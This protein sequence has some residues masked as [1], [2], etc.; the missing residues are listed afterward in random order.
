[1]REDLR[2][3]DT[4]IDQKVE[5]A[6][7]AEAIEVTEATEVIEVIEVIEAAEAAE[8]TEVA[9]AAS[10]KEITEI[11]LAITIGRTPAIETSMIDLM[12]KVQHKGL[13]RPL[14]KIHL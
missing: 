13:R 8:V 5:I 3:V 12:M 6:D 14:T 2:E 7:M 11:S 9:E 4:I 10:N 1:V